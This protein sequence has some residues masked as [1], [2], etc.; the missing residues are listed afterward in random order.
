MPLPQLFTP[1]NVTTVD[2]YNWLAGII[3]SIVSVKPK[4]FGEYFYESLS[5][6]P[7]YAWWGVNHSKGYLIP[8]DLYA[9]N[10]RINGGNYNCFTGCELLVL[11]GLGIPMLGAGDLP[12]N[13]YS[14]L[15]VTGT[16]IEIYTRNYSIGVKA[17][18]SATNVDEP[19]FNNYLYGASDYFNSN[20]ALIVSSEATG[21]FPGSEL[22][23]VSSC[24]DPGE[25]PSQYFYAA[26]IPVSTMDPYLVRLASMSGH[27][28]SKDIIMPFD[29][30]GGRLSPEVYS[31]DQDHALL[32]SAITNQRVLDGIHSGKLFDAT[33][34]LFRNFSHSDSG[35]NT[36]TCSSLDFGA[37]PRIWSPQFFDA[38]DLADEAGVTCRDSAATLYSGDEILRKRH[39]ITN[40][41]LYEIIPY[42]RPGFI[43]TKISDVKNKAIEMDIPFEFRR[44]STPYKLKTS[45]FDIDENY[46]ETIISSGEGIYGEGIFGGRKNET[47][48]NRSSRLLRN[49]GTYGEQL[50]DSL[51]YIPNLSQQETGFFEFFGSFT[52]SGVTFEESVA[53]VSAFV[54]GD[55]PNFIFQTRGYVPWVYEAPNFVFDDSTT[56]NW[57]VPLH[58]IRS[59]STGLTALIHH[60]DPSNFASFKMYRNDMV[61]SQTITAGAGMRTISTSLSNT[62]ATF[63]PSLMIKCLGHPEFVSYNQGIFCLENTVNSRHIWHACLTK[64]IIQP[65]FKIDTDPEWKEVMGY[66][67]GNFH[68]KNCLFEDYSTFG[69][70]H[71]IFKKQVALAKYT[72]PAEEEGIGISTMRTYG[73]PSDE[74]PIEFEL[75]GFSNALCAPFSYQ[76]DNIDSM[77]HLHIEDYDVLQYPWPLNKEGR[78]YAMTSTIP[79]IDLNYFTKEVAHVSSAVSIIDVSGHTLIAGDVDG[80]IYKINLF[81]DD[82]ISA[83]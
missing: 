23:L 78:I 29:Y 56:G 74:S 71:K 42:W 41:N 66:S 44:L 80:G 72:P 32:F 54:T 51:I 9:S 10:C 82:V 79:E 5:L 76:L 55:E 69:S 17:V 13:I 52:G 15:E 37:G 6:S 45:T 21:I 38:V 31:T 35:S 59:I 22:N 7:D 20:G 81:I 70:N 8:K 30:D 60:T 27:S 43:W 24:G 11:S 48:Q 65:I 53:R 39:L 67:Q 68:P 62:P 34:S 1:F 19:N 33:S 40:K 28:K 63:S 75:C 4:T 36:L 49:E 18:H 77:T 46:S 57:C 3:N 14:S 73:I 50:L 47:V 26:T 64:A 58:D 16:G 61:K 83:E 2:Q 25:S 12:D